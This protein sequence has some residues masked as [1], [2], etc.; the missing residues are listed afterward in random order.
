MEKKLLK[1]KIDVS[2]L[3]EFRKSHNLTQKQ[4]AEKLGVATITYAQKEQNK[5]AITPQ[6][7]IRIR[8]CFKTEMN[9]FF[10]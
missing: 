10:D 6:D 9:Y 7:L 3:V 8:R 2:K 4:M 1:E 5:V